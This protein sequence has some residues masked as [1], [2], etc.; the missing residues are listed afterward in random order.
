MKDAE[1]RRELL[2][3]YLDGDLRLEEEAQVADLL[4]A[5]PEAR[6]FLRDVA[7]QA[8]TVA[9]LERAE[10]GRQAEL[11]TRRHGALNRREPPGGTKSP[12]RR[13]ARWPLA[14][15]AVAIVALLASVFFLRPNEET[16]IA[17][18]I[19]L[20]GSLIWTGDGGQIV[21]ELS[22]GTELSGG[23]IEGMAPDSWF[24]LQFNDGSTVMISGNSILTFSEDGQKALR[25]KVGS[26]S[27]NVVAQ[28]KG[29]PMLIRTPSA[30][31]EVLG[32]QF[33]V[34]AGLSSTT[35]NVS[36]GSVRVKRLSDGRTVVVPAKHRVIAAAD[37]DMSPVRASDSVHRWK[38]RLHLG[39]DGAYGKWLPANDKH[40]A[41]L[42]AIPFV[43]RENR[44]VTLYLLGLSVI[45]ADSSPVIVKPGSRFV[46]RGHLA[47]AT[48]VFFGIRVTH[49]NGEFAGKFLARRQAVKL[50]DESDFEAAF[51]LDEFDLD[52]CVRDRKDELPGKPEG[53]VVTGVWCFTHNAGPAGLEVTEVEL[54]PPTENELE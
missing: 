23:T 8:V 6:A 43:P 45:R 32:T 20:S 5:D 21:R 34:E 3:R 38:S 14:I 36:E 13:F 27:A 33:E 54:I 12:G 25:L 28:P 16:K 49:P 48:R 46:V 18:I 15:A 35:L 22:V 17:K 37:R 19:G 52:P 53:L 24:E 31:L 29:R 26:F 50:N 41:S 30:L 44:S 40:A 39:P 51:R 1:A 4:R 9:D 47:V 42:K 10:Q 11:T 2:L 7:E